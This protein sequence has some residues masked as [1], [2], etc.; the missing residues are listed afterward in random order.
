MS[1]T[2]YLTRVR[3]CDTVLHIAKRLPTE[4]EMGMNENGKCERCLEPNVSLQEITEDNYHYKKV[5]E[6]CMR[7]H[8]NP[9]SYKRTTKQRMHLDI[10]INR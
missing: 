3:Q 1:Q 2:K 4:R 5:C 10:L 8:L 6:H 7:Q 9:V